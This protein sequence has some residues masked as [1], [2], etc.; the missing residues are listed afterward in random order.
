[1]TPVDF[2]LLITTTLGNQNLIAKVVLLIFLSIYILF[3]LILFFQ[4]KQLSR[5]INQKGFSGVIE[6]LSFVHLSIA[7]G[8]LAITISL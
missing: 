2:T 1:M 7:V 5:I 3:S 4:I 8:L 6:S